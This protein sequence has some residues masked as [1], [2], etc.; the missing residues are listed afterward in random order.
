[1]TPADEMTF[2]RTLQ[3]NIRYFEV[4]GRA[5]LGTEWLRLKVVARMA[6]IALV[7]AAGG[8]NA[9]DSWI[10]KGNLKSPTGEWCCGEGDCGVFDAD[11]VTPVPGGYQVN[12]LITIEGT[13]ERFLVREFV[14]NAEALPSQNGRYTRCHRPDKTRR[15]FFFPPPNS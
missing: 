4:L 5:P 2:L 9:H 15:C 6:A 8:A 1:M 12:G 13:K 14:P 11:A 10:S 3:R 7:L